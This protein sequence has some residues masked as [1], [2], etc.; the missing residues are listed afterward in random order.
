MTNE[1]LANRYGKSSATVRKQRLFW[2]AIAGLLVIG[3]FAWSIAINFGSPA[4]LTATV[5]NFAALN[6]NQ[7][8]VTINVTNPNQQDGLCAIN[9][10][11]QNFAIVGYKEIAISGSLGK[12]PQIDA[13][14]NTT[15]IGVSTT[16]DRCW[17]K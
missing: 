15:N 8:S 14:I 16:V 5:Q 17:F 11:S 7:T 9:V 2:S 4:T 13:A 12:S 10:L 1:Y 3:F 6:K